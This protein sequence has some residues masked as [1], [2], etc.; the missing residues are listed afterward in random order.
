MSLIVL[1]NYKC[2]Y[3][4]YLF[5]R[6][7]NSI[8]GWLDGSKLCPLTRGHGFNSWR[9]HFLVI[10]CFFKTK[11]ILGDKTL[12]QTISNDIFLN[13][14]NFYIY[15]S[16]QKMNNFYLFYFKKHNYIF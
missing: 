15:V 16:M 2:I 10:F 13:K 8:D 14:V 11:S 6:K 9:G 1:E 12:F 7:T 4:I 5:Q 3:Y